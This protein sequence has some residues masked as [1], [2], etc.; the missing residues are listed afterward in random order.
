MKSSTQLALITALALTGGLCHWLI[1]GRPSG[2]PEQEHAKAAERGEL[3][4]LKEGEVRLED[5][6]KVEGLLWV[7]PFWKNYR[8]RSV[9][10]RPACTTPVVHRTPRSG[11]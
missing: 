7:D 3:P 4:P 6:E 10:R 11:C 5:L 8:K 1:D 2:N 9:V